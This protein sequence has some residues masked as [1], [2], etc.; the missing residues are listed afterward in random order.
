MTTPDPLLP[1]FILDV[2]DRATGRQVAV[3][4]D[5]H[6]AR[7]PLAALLRKVFHVVP[8]DL[9][10]AER[11]PDEQADT[12]FRM[13]DLIYPV[14]DAGH[15]QAEPYWGIVFRHQHDGFAFEPD[16]PALFERIRRAGRP[17]LLVLPLEIDRHDIGYQRNWRGF[18][19]RR[20]ARFRP[21]I[22]RLLEEAIPG[23]IGLDGAGSERRFVEA[24][25][26]RIWNADFENYTRFL[27]PADGSAPVR[28]K[29]GDETVENIVSGRGGVCTEKVSALKLITD[30]FG[31]D[32]RP[33]F[34]G[35]RTH[36]PL[37][38][39]ELRRMLDEL[40][41]YDFTFAKR[42]LR[43]WDH[44]A[45]EYTL[46]DGSSWLVDPSNG[47]IPFLCAPSEPYLAE[48]ADKQMVPVR[49]L[50]VEEPV[51]YHRTPEALGLDFLFAW[52]TSVPDMDLLQVFDNQLGFVVLRDFF[53]SPITWGS[54]NKREVALQSWRSYAD[55][56]GLDMAIL[57]SPTEPDLPPG[58]IAN[59]RRRA[60][61]KGAP[62]RRR[63]RTPAVLAQFQAAHPSLAANCATALAGLEG[64]YQHYILAQHGIDKPFHADLVILDRRRLLLREARPAA[65]ER[66][67]VPSPAG[68]A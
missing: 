54:R 42:Y 65:K 16:Q 33:V 64:R 60:R 21:L 55:E 48:G 17:D 62:V 63:R 14:D 39:E 13:Q 53:V 44:V 12:F 10:A 8:E 49:T 37:P 27:P 5:E 24:V 34:A 23:G 4:I 20:A 9:T 31:I 50:A 47:N 30:A 32:S 7:Q 19:A 25:A 1:L 51:G 28:L 11:L 40:R 36:A 26:L 18:H 57:P 43:Y 35:P 52:E 29:T 66:A 2:L 67:R 6:A 56:H 58:I 68:T 59:G 15:L 3:Q 41:T 22:D 38:V 45:L 61:R 46:S